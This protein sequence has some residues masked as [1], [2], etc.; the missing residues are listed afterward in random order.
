MSNLCWFFGEFYL[1]RLL[2]NSFRRP[3]VFRIFWGGQFGWFRWNFFIV[4][5]GVQIRMSFSRS[6]SSKALLNSFWWSWRLFT[7]WGLAFVT[8]RYLRFHIRFNSDI[9]FQMLSWYVE[10]AF[11]HWI[12][13][14]YSLSSASLVLRIRV[15]TSDS[16]VIFVIK[17][18]AGIANSRFQFGFYSDICLQALSLLE[19][20]FL[21]RI[22]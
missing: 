22:L 6:L 5:A 17:H 11:L 16:I 4:L 12:P 1:P 3:W 19:F 15:F 18:F 21:P 9:R 7:F 13:L 20:A 14:W 2:Q 10:F 8:A